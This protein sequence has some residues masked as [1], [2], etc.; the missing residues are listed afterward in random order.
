VRS[1]TIF[2]LGPTGGDHPAAI[3]RVALTGSFKTLHN[4]DR[5]SSRGRQ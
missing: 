2:T 3:S 5:F 4:A 1:P